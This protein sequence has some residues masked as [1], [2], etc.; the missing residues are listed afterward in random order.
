MR[1]D[2]IRRSD[3][4]D[5]IHSYWKGEINKLP[6]TDSEYGEVIEEDCDTI[7]KRNK[8]LSTRIKA[9]P[10]ADRPQ[11]EWKTEF[12][13]NGWNDFWDYTCSNCGKKYERADNILY[14]SN[15]CPNCG[16]RMKEVVNDIE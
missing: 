7:L 4:I 16:A 5:A 9:V 13:G 3:A 2:L 12:N 6:V 11:G 14:K 15:Y 8:E 1:E 10:T